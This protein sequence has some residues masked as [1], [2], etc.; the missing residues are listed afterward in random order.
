MEIG[1]QDHCKVQLGAKG[2]CEWD[3]DLENF[4][5]LCSYTNTNS[6]KMFK[7]E[8]RVKHEGDQ[9]LWRNC[10]AIMHSYTN[11]LASPVDAISITKI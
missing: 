2:G 1:F 8:Q 7:G 9:A 11:K 10:L 3:Q 6:N 4:P 5:S